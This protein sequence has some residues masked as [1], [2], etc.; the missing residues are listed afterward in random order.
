MITSIARPGLAEAIARLRAAG[1]QK[2]ADFLRAFGDETQA[3][4]GAAQAA[5]SA[6]M[7]QLDA[8]N[9]ARAATRHHK[10][11]TPAGRADPARLEPLERA[12]AAAEAELARLRA[13]RVVLVEAWQVKRRQLD[14][15]VDAA[16]S[17]ISMI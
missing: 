14:R 5:Q 12:E 11:S 16:L 7:D 2:E 13:R 17:A 6:E 1:C 4:G 8:V 10:H 9:A 3:S 15:L